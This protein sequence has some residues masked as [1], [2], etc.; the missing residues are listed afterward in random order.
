MQNKLF[1]ECQSGF[2]PGDSCVAQLLSIKREIYKSFDCNPPADT[3]RIFLDIS[4]AFDKV[5]HEG[6]IFKSKIYGIDGNLLK[7]LIN[8]L[9]DRK[10]K[11]VLNGKTSSWKNILSGVPQGSVLGPILFLIYINDLPDGIKSI[12]KIFADDRS[13]F[14]K[15]NDKNY[16][17]V[18]L[19]NDL[20]IISNWAIQWKM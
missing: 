5:G 16:S 14:S 9:K 1:T 17:T 7:L 10:Q 12:C 8:Y 18:E 2:I 11:V 15:V 4:K 20:K 19:N 13:L 3:R 6:V